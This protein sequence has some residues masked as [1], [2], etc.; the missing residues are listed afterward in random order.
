MGGKPS[1]P[2]L[3][4]IG[5]PLRATNSWLVWPSTLVAFVGRHPQD[6]DIERP[7]FFRSALRAGWL[8][9]LPQCISAWQTFFDDVGSKSSQKQ[10]HQIN[11]NGGSTKSGPMFHNC[12]G[13]QRRIFAF[14]VWQLIGRDGHI[15][16]NCEG[17]FPKE[18]SGIWWT[19]YRH[20]R[21]YCHWSCFITWFSGVRKPQ[22]VLFQQ[23]TGARPMSRIAFRTGGKNERQGPLEMERFSGSN[24]IMEI[25]GHLNPPKRLWGR[26]SWDSLPGLSPT[27]FCASGWTWL[28]GGRRDWIRHRNNTRMFNCQWLLKLN[29]GHK[30]IVE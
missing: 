20:Q 3:E 25:H 18:T 8:E 5:P 16:L 19:Y 7:D 29:K 6:L 12:S 28:R 21:R 27:T 4:L 2:I 26:T 14:P 15:L 1:H 23:A 22:G 24:F 9:T 30:N 13:W 17:F 11:G 10:M